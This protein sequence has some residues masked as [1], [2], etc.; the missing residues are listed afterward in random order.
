MQR[1]FRV[2]VMVLVGPHNP[3]PK[4]QK[5]ATG[6]PLAPFLLSCC[7]FSGR[8]R[9]PLCP[10]PLARAPP[11]PRLRPAGPE[12]EDA[13]CRARRASGD[14]IS[15]CW[16]RSA[17]SSPPPPPSCTSTTTAPSGA[18]LASVGTGSP[19]CCSPPL[20]PPAVAAGSRAPASRQRLRASSASLRRS[21]ASC[22][23]F[24]TRPVERH[25]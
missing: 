3:E 9:A 2:E 1:L 23:G 25:H 4:N 11:R 6:A 14:S 7:A 19:C 15:C 22:S 20:P 17:S 10:A 16:S 5:G 13:S 24:R 12:E 8:R 21:T 18:P